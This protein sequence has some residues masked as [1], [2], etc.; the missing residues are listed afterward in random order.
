MLV[1]AGVALNLTAASHVFLID[2]WWNPACEVR[3]DLVLA[4][5]CL[6]HLHAQQSPAAVHMHQADDLLPCY[7]RRK[8]RTGS[9]GW[10]NTSPSMW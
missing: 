9:T 7:D 5:G 8:R 3:G 2:I 6:L 1:P 10:A 4:C